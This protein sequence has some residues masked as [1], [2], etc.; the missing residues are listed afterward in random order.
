MEAYHAPYTARHRYWTGLLIFARAIIYLITAANVSG[1][2]QN[3]II[4]IIVVMSCVA[5]LKMSIAV[6][7][8]QNWLIDCLESF[9]YSNIIFLASFTLYNKSIGNN[10]DGIAYMS[11]VLSMMV[12]LFILSYHVYSYTSL[13]L[14][15]RNYCKFFAGPGLATSQ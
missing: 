5:L 1:D 4:A 8:Y 3:Q 14:R 11:V 7:L 6:K 2:P 13:C 9:F 12:T 15:L 10:Q